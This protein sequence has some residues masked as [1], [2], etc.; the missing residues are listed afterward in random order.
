MGEKSSINSVYLLK[1][2]KIFYHHLIDSKVF[3]NLESFN[4][5][6]ACVIV[7]RYCSVVVFGAIK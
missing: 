3:M 4:A 6:H 1:I 5:C 7:L 2:K